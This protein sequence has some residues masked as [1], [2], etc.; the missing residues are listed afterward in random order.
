MKGMAPTRP[1]LAG[2]CSGLVA[3]SLGTVVY[4]LHCPEMQA[5]FLAVW[6]VLGMLLPTAAGA[7][8]GRKILRW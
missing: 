3:A 2:A 8:L 5:P 6:Y 1:A 4:A 7:L